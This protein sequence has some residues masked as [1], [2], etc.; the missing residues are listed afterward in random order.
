MPLLVFS[1]IAIVGSV[2]IRAT[3]LSLK[4]DVIGY[5]TQVTGSF[6]SNHYT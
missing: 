2:C 3:Y 1:A 6:L 5:Q 4:S